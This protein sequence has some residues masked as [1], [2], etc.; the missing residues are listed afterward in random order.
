MS[1]VQEIEAAIEK[2]SP[3]EQRQIRDWIDDLLEDELEFTDEFKAKIE[4][5]ER[6]MS[7]GRASRTRQPG[8]PA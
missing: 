3:E 2:L 8:K 6:D 1:N 5:S 7:A 4:Q